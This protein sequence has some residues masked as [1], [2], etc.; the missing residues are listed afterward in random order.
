MAKEESS[1]GVDTDVSITRETLPFNHC[2]QLKLT[3]HLC[4]TASQIITTLKGKIEE[5]KKL[6]SIRIGVGAMCC[7]IFSSVNVTAEGGV[8]NE[9]QLLR[10]N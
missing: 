6:L 7:S 5:K 3:L 9:L 8:Q 2:C 4:T 1:P 10:L